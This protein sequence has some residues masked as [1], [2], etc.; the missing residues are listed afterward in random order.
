VLVCMLGFA[1][2]FFFD[3]CCYTDQSLPRLGPRSTYHM[4]RV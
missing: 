2:G 1:A 4:E 3:R